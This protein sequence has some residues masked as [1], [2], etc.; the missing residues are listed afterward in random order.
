MSKIFI[1]QHRAYFTDDEFAISYDAAKTALESR[2]Y[3][4]II[5]LNEQENDAGIFE[6]PE[7]DLFEKFEARVISK[8]LII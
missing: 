3:M 5:P 1:I 7:D 6:K 4:E 2:G 8:P